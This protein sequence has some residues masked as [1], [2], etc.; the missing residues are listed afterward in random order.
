MSVVA[1]AAAA[2]RAFYSAH[3]FPTVSYTN[4]LAVS[5]LII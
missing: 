1:I 2:A 5:S 3:A 4:Y